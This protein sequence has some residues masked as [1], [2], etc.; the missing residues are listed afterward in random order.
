MS[1]GNNIVIYQW[2]ISDIGIGMSQEFMK[3]IF[4]PFAQERSDARSI[5][6]YLKGKC[7]MTIN[8]L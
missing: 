1:K 8:S 5:Y 6:N 3:Y 7:Q 2:I 4:E